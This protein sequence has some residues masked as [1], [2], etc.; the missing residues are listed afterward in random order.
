MLHK[1]T[2]EK[3]TGNVII[4]RKDFEELINKVHAAAAMKNDYV[5]IKN[6]EPWKENE[7]LKKGKRIVS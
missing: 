6:L 1:E 2:V 4:P 7:K 5:R 3:E